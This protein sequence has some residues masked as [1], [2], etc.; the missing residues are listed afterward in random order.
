MIDIIDIVDLKNIHNLNTELF[1]TWWEFL[2][3]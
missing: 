1:F 2:G 3:C